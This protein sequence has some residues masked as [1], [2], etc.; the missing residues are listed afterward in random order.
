MVRGSPKNSGWFADGVTAR[1]A[2][3]GCWQP[4]GHAG[5]ALFQPGALKVCTMQIPSFSLIDSTAGAA[6]IIVIPVLG[7]ETPQLLA[8]NDY[9]ITAERLAALDFTGKAEATLRVLITDGETERPALLVGIGGEREL[10]AIRRAA[11]VAARALAEA[12]QV[13]VDFAGSADEVEAFATGFALGAHKL[14]RFLSKA[15]EHDREV[16]FVAGG[17][18]FA[19]ALLQ[20]SVLSE[21]AA[22]ARDLANTPPSDLVPEDFAALAQDVLAEYE[23]KVEIWDEAALEE[24][25]C[26]GILGVGRG[27]DN[28][29]RLVQLRYNPENAAK[30]IALVGKGITFDTGGL[31]LK[32]AGS[33][34][35]MK[36]DMSG[37]ASVLA[38]LL[39]VAKLGLHVQVTGYCCLA[40]NMPSG[41]AI[42]PDDVLTMRNGTTVEVTNTDAEGRLV[43]ADGLCLASEQRPDLIIDIA[44]LTGAQVVALGSRTTGLM[45][46]TDDWRDAAVAAAKQTGE[47]LWPMPIPEELDDALKSNVADIVNS[48]P[49]YREAGMLF[50]GAFLERF[51][52]EDADGKPLPWL[53]FDIAGPA[54]S[55]SAYGYI[56]KGATGNPVRTLVELIAAAQ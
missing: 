35:G 44:T 42:K 13:I 46:N 53:H 20:A 41:S 5:T 26:G 23:V 34:L 39:A 12:E 22:L 15:D 24:A 10:E 45:G 47:P 33:M 52:G 55:D 32:P 7:S 14:D 21:S 11:G 1:A 37:A 31:S 18:E 17:E 27:S 9:G 29:P 56:N 48:K 43:L 4:L 6:G 36:F 38:T 49:G 2:P 25:G 19:E 51:V 40:E 3:T 16:A 8:A 54:N 28:P 30:H 50:A